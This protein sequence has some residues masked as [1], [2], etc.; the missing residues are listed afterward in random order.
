MHPWTRRLTPLLALVLFAACGGDG[1]AGPGAISISG[2]WRITWTNMSGSGVSCSTSS[3]E[4]QIT[5]S[6]TTFT[7]SS[8]S[9]WTLTCIA[10]GATDSETFTGAAI[11]SGQISGS[12]ITFNLATSAAQQTG[13]ISGNSIS[14]TATWTLDLGTGTLVL[15]GQFGGLKV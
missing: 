14:G 13:S 3:I 9:S 12:T 4:I 5:Q 10:G 15:T 8:N 1:P 2:A 7:G 6:G 11:T